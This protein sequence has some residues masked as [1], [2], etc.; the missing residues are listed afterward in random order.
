MP[1]HGACNL[2]SI[3]LSEYVI[4]PFAENARFDFDSFCDDVQIATEA[5]DVIVS[6]NMDNHPLPEQRELAYNYR[7]IGLGIM[8]L[9]DALIKM[10]IVYGSEKSKKLI[11]AIFRN[12]LLFAVF[13][14]WRLADQ[15]G[16]FPKFT[17][18]VSKADILKAVD[19]RCDIDKLRNCSL[20]SI[21]PTGS[22]GTMLDV[23]TGCEPIFAMSYTRKTE[24]LNGEEEKSYKVYTGIAKEYMDTFN[25][26]KLPDYFVESKDIAWKDRVEMQAIMQEYVDTAISSTINLPNETTLEEIEQLYL[27]AWEKGLKG[28]TIFRD[29]CKRM[30]ILTKDNADD[31]EVIKKD[32]EETE[33]SYDNLPR[34]FIIKT[35]DNCV[36]KKRTLVTGCGTLHC[37]AFFDPIT[38]ELLETYFSKGSR[39][40]CNNFMIG[41]SRMISLAARGGIDIYSIVDQLQSSG[42]CPSYAVRSATKRDTSKG[43]CCPVAIG[44]ALLD[45]YNEM[46]RDIGADEAESCTEKKCSVEKS[47]DETIKHQVQKAQS[48]KKK[49]AIGTAFQ[50]EGCG[51]TL[52]FEG[53]CNIC[54]NC[55]WSKCE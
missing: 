42:S 37:E 5:L 12:M 32:D 24:S 11:K 13:A 41:L 4:N 16:A 14:S 6:E 46:Q 51:A 36:G 40:G 22:L 18:D 30:G 27:Y 8:G 15:K 3:N 31:E 7:N 1:K 20:L 44:N 39:G 52:I 26:D 28:V 43:S 38:G 2:G 47:I 34:G 33:Y 25:T 23:S 50:C 9:H 53:G 54:R 19:Y 35:D 45:M 48:A 55:G 21:A 10:G 29:G 17:K 49:M